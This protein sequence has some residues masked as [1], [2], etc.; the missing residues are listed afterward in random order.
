MCVDKFV[1]NIMALHDDGD[2]DGV[3]DDNNNV[4]LLK[5]TLVN[6]RRLVETKIVDVDDDH[7]SKLVADVTCAI[8]DIQLQ[9]TFK[10]VVASVNVN[11]RVCEQCES[12]FASAT[13][14]IITLNR[15]VCRNCGSTIKEVPL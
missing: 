15:Y 1:S 12:S 8:V 11:F 9:D 6:L 10:D 13:R 7:K 14:K 2:D 4:E 5:S 3:N